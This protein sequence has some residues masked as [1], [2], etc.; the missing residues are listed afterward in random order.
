M[1]KL[2]LSEFAISL[3][4]GL[5]GFSGLSAIM[6]AAIL[7]I[8]LSSGFVAYSWN[9]YCLPVSRFATVYC[10]RA[11]LL[12]IASASTS[13]VMLPALPSS[14]NRLKLVMGHPPLSTGIYHLKV[15]E[16]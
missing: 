8:V 16:V 4:G 13:V 3:E 1:V 10:V 2:V 12:F 6:N 15:R 14:L 11:G 5:C 9:L 7:E